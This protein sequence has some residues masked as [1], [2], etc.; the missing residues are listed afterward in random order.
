MKKKENVIMTVSVGDVLN[1]MMI[2][3]DMSCQKII[4]WNF[5]KFLG[6]IPIYCKKKPQKNEK[7]CNFHNTIMRFGSGK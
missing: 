7:Y 1:E 6:K 5:T 4:G 3:I 2:V